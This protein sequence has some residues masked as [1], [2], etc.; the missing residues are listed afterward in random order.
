MLISIS[1]SVVAFLL[2]ATTNYHLAAAQSEETETIVITASREAVEALTVSSNIDKFTSNEIQSVAHNHIQELL[3]RSPGVNLQRGNGQESLTAIRSPVLTGAGACGA[4]LMAE[5]NIPLRAAGFC[6]L[7]E[8]FEAHTEQARSI[9]VIRG[10][11]TAF[12]GSNALHGIVN[13]F[14]PEVPGTAQTR[15][16]LEFGSYDYTRL[17]VQ[18]GD[19]NKQQG[20]N[21][22]LTVDHDGGYRDDAGF[23]QQKFS[24]RH[25]FS[26]NK[27]IVNSGVTITNLEQETAGFIEGLDSYKDS[28]IARSN[29]NPEAYRNASAFRAWSRFEY[30]L[31]NNVHWLMTPYLRVTEMAFMQHFLPGKPLEEN[32]QE[33]IGF[34]SAYYSEVNDTLKLSIGLDGEISQGY[35]MQTQANPTDG[36]AFLQATIPE[37]KHYDYEVDA[38]MVA[39]FVHLDWQFADSLKL[40]AGIRY[41]QM[42]YDYD[43]QMLDGRTREDGTE[44]G[45][46]GCRYSRPADSNDSFNH[47]S[48][49]LGLSYQLNDNSLLFLNIANGFRTPQATELYRLQQHQ[50]ITDLDAEEIDSYELGLRHSDSSLAY[51]ITAYQMKKSNVIYRDSNYFNLSN[52]ETDHQGIEAKIDYAINENFRLSVNT[53]MAKHQ[54]AHQQILSGVNIQGNDV[55]TAPRHFGSV[56]LRWDMTS[57]I[58]VELEWLYQ[59]SYFMDAENL[60]QYDGHKLFNFRA[61]WRIG[62]NWKAFA[63]INNLADTRYAERADYTIFTDERYFPGMPLTVFIGVQWI[64]GI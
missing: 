40:T 13:V 17:K 12:Y 63:R 2:C 48:P 52:G 46:G 33:S 38:S 50:I 24:A 9:E 34:Q 41:E 58:S 35:L 60:H 16:G 1:R 37:G 55:D 20:Y 7:N 26:N 25:L 3:V 47:W 22:A 64:T 15:L 44:C 43:N 6:N 54:Y 51:E 62:Q 30:Q 11:G 32:G 57:D 45:F 56:Q 8:L 39:P 18:A 5:D 36:S 21:L 61:N 49:K 19:S 59:G 28:Q 14:T 27:L 23:A 31:E 53:S 29:F 4:F 10:P 42:N